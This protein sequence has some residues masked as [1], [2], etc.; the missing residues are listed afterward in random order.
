MFKK[1]PYDRTYLDILTYA[2]YAYTQTA[3]SPDYEFYSY[4][5]AA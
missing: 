3:Y 5:G 2:R 4:A 1:I